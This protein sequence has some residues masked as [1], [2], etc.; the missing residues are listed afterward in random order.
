MRCARDQP[1]AC[2]V[3]V[4]L[5]FTQAAAAAT[6]RVAEGAAAQ[7]YRRRVQNLERE[8]SRRLRPPSVHPHF[9]VIATLASASSSSPLIPW[10]RYAVIP[11]C[12]LKGASKCHASPTTIRTRLYQRGS[13]LMWL[14]VAAAIIIRA[15]LHVADVDHPVLN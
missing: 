12:S 2:D 4:A 9:V 11:S 7:G 15:P 1:I 14:S 5:T 6:T 13:C 10:V 3:V 8:L